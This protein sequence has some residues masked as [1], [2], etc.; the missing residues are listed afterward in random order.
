MNSV[1][2]AESG[3]AVT[4]LSLDWSNTKQWPTEKVDV[5][6][7]SDLVYSQTMVPTLVSVVVGLL[8]K[9]GL[10]YYAAS[11]SERDGMVEFVALMKSSG[12]VLETEM[13]APSEYHSNPLH[14]ATQS[15]CDR[16]FSGL[17][18]KKFMLHA[19]RKMV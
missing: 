8:P 7:G 15:K 10:F 16:H 18:T 17:K 2:L 3:V 19:W 9:G 1:C 4:T 14:Q 5:L 13:L 6:I 12:F 11:T